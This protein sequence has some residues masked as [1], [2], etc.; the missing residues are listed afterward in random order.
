ME[1]SPVM[2]EFL[3]PTQRLE[4]FSCEELRGL[5]IITGPHG[6]AEVTY[7][8][9]RLFKGIG[10]RHYRGEDR[11]PRRRDIRLFYSGI[12]E[13]VNQANPGF[14]SVA[15]LEGASR[16]DVAR[17]PTRDSA[18]YSDIRGEKAA[19]AWT[20]VGK[21]MQIGAADGGDRERALWVTRAN[22]DIR[23]YLVA[24][25]MRECMTYLPSR[26][27]SFED[28]ITKTI[29]DRYGISLLTLPRNVCNLQPSDFTFNKLC[30]LY[31]TITNREFG[32]GEARYCYE[33]IEEPTFTRPANPTRMQQLTLEEVKVRHRCMHNTTHRWYWQGLSN[34]CLLVGA[35]HFERVVRIA[36]SL[37][38]GYESRPRN[39]HLGESHPNSM[40][41]YLPVKENQ[42]LVYTPGM[43]YG[44]SDP[45][46]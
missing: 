31:K 35:P 40:S 25:M 39:Y 37:R 27:H 5:E 32:A 42:Q 38:D 9:P 8:G 34:V 36:M 19:L 13:F 14:Y 17:Y 46:C 22:F 29:T 24:C 21:G 6:Y 45:G 4:N 7:N 2:G 18:F 12:D 11:D 16:V 23:E 3:S 28:H 20:A 41:F 10:M 30:A 15:N 33:Q 43:H 26:G 44:D 1:R